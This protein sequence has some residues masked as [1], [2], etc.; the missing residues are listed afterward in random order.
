[1]SS[2][3]PA[4]RECVLIQKASRIG[5]TELL[6]RNRECLG[7]RYLS[8]RVLPSSGELSCAPLWID[9]GECET[10]ADLL[11]E[12]LGAV[13]EYTA[14]T[15]AAGESCWDGWTIAALGD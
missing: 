15:S 2:Q 12:V 8:R 3:V 10:D 1:M 13:N 7:S 5:I 6:V 9:L 14:T 4:P 11:A